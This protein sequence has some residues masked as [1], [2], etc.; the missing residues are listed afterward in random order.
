MSISVNTLPL[1]LMRANCYIVTIP[2][3]DCALVVDPGEYSQKLLDRLKEL[4]IKKLEYILLT[5]AHFDHMTGADALRSDYCGK[6]VIHASDEAYLADENASLSCILRKPFVPISADI[7]VSDSDSLDFGPEKIKVIH[8]PGHTPGS[9]CY[10]IGDCLFSGD[11]LFRLMAGRTDF[12]GGSET[13]MTE[14]M[15]K[16]KS[17]PDHLK[18]YPGHDGATELAFEKKKN[19]FMKGL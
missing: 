6:I 14:S 19:P 9:V 7:V 10:L 4:G 2:G 8:T 12:P 5:H 3:T 15:K 18:V 17:L 11:T 1:G 13:Q 16:L